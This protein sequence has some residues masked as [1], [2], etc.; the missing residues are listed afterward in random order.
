MAET[1]ADI[2]LTPDTRPQVVTDAEKLIDAEVAD[3]SGVSGMAV[4][5]G[6]SMVKKLK[7][8]I[9]HDAVDSLL[10]DFLNRLQPYYADFQ[11]AGASS[12]PEYFDGRS[13]EIADALLA[14]TDERAAGSQRPAIKKAYD[15]L[16]PKGKENVE[17]SLPRFGELIQ[18]HAKA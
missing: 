7:P 11:A 14:I 9:I 13:G 5:G 16:R 8:G 12:L 10:D 6:Y 3:K 17:E 1:L 2:L 15:K 18:K 4:K